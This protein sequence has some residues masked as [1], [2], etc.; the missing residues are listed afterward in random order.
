MS[1]TSIAT[2]PHADQPDVQLVTRFQCRHV[3]AD[4]RRCGSIALREQDF[5]Y[6]HHATRRPAQDLPARRSRQASFALAMPEDRPAIQLALGEIIQRIASH[7]IDRRRAALILYGL[8]IACSTLRHAPVRGQEPG[9]SP[10]ADITLDPALGAIAPRAEY[11]APQA[12]KT[13]EQILLEQWH[14][15]P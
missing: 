7:G 14:K 3:L 10:I 6:F 2:I 5:C 8:Q 4:G 1:E 13:L 11:L 12:E 9:T 15:Q